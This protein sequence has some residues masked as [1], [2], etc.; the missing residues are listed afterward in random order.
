MFELLRMPID[1]LDYAIA[2]SNGLGSLTNSA[3]DN[4]EKTFYIEHQ[5]VSMITK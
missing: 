4:F 5:N 1:K 2:I 3:P